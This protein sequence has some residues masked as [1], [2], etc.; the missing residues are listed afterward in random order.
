MSACVITSYHFLAN[1]FP[2]QGIGQLIPNMTL[3][4]ASAMAPRVFCTSGVL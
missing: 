4:T 1:Y 2:I 3:Y